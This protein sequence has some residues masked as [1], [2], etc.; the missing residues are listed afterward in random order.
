MHWLLTRLMVPGG[1]PG[2]QRL[3]DAV[4]VAGVQALSGSRPR[5]VV[6]VMGADPEDASLSNPATVRQY[7]AS[8]RV[9]LFIWSVVK[10]VET[11]ASPLAVWG[12]IED[13]SSVSRLRAA[14]A[15]L[16]DELESQWIVWVEGTHLP[17]SIS[18]AAGTEGAAELEL[19]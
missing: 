16:R 8:I 18:L 9:P 5:A 6:V 1:V 4:A 17:Q 10:P 12:K 3:S 19:P 11:N 7:L 14:V 2:K 13:V 15:D